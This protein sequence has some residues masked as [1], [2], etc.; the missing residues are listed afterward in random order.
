MTPEALAKAR[1]AQLSERLRQV[2]ADAQAVA[3][4]GTQNALSL[5][6][7]MLQRTIAP[8][9]T[10]IDR[11][12]ARFGLRLPSAATPSAT[13]GRTGLAN[14]LAPV[15]GILDSVQQMLQRLFSRG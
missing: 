7:S 1:I 15:R 6:T 3:A 12:L 5:A 11:V 2:I 9:L 14:L 13:G 4:S 10:S 8:L